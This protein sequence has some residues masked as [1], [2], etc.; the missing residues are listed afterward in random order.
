M[1]VQKE[2]KLIMSI[3]TLIIAV[4]F[5]TSYVAFG[6]GSSSTSTTTVAPQQ[7]YPVIGYANSILLSYKN[8]SV[9][10]MSGPASNYSGPVSKLLS[11]MQANSSI[12]N[13]IPLGSQ[14][15]VYT[16]GINPYQLYSII[17]N[18]LE[19]NSSAVAANALEGLNVSSQALVSLPAYAS[20]YYGSQAVP[21]RMPA[22][23]S[24]S[25]S[26]PLPL[27]AALK[28]KIRAVIVL[29]NNTYASVYDNQ[30]NISMVN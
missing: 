23:Y 7:T 4:M 30:L 29:N 19:S 14:F 22:N 6:N 2:K 1:A 15:D 5:V 26:A 12:S 20:L 10:K 24:L 27:N 9:V 21:V 28:L 11:A 3:G 13:Y 16:S 17:T 8:Y 18:S 25:I